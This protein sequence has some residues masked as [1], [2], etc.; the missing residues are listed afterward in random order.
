LLWKKSK[1]DKGFERLGQTWSQPVKSK[2]KIAS[3]TK[4]VLIFAGGYDLSEDDFN[5]KNSAYRDDNN[6]AQGNAIYMVDAEKGDLLW[7]ASKNGSN[8]NLPDMNYSIPATVS[9][10]DIDRDGLADQLVVGDT[11]GQVWRLFIHNGKTANTLVSASGFSGNEPFA[12]LGEDNP[13]NARRFY[14]EADVER[15]NSGNGRLMINIGSG[16]RAHP[17][18]KNINDRFYSLRANLL[19]NDIKEPLREKDL[20]QA[21]R[22]FDSDY[23]ENKVIKTIEGGAGWYLALNAAPGEKMLSTAWMNGR[24]IEFNTY[25][26]ALNSDIIG[27]QVKP[28]KNHTYRLN[29]RSAAPPVERIEKSTVKGVADTIIYKAFYRENNFSGILSSGTSASA[30]GQRYRINGMFI[31][32]EGSPC[33]NP[34]GCKTYWID[35][36]G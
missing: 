7:S 31:E 29:S 28:G 36:D 3:E 9:V 12:K 25:V 16:Y 6:E 20:H 27:C 8:L 30:D 11:G 32:Q 18:N 15:E 21:T 26:P 17:L 1:A 14:H 5:E 19:T 4:D 34:K 13:Q 2:I 33:L 24:Y 10:I 23:D 35:L 22:V